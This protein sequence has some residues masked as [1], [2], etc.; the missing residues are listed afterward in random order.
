MLYCKSTELK[1][2]VLIGFVFL[3]ETIMNNQNRNQNNNQ[4]QKMN[5]NNQNQNNNQKQNNR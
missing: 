1:W 2:L 5:Q 3:E 4:N